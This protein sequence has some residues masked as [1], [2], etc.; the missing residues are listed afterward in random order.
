MFLMVLVTMDLNRSSVHISNS[1][2]LMLKIFVWSLDA[3]YLFVLLP[4]LVCQLGL[5]FAEL[6]I[7]LRVCRNARL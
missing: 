1:I 2:D 4:R 6:M 7:F 5:G 3:F